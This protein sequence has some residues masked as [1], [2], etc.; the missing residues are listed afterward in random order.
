MCF[1]LGNLLSDWRCREFK[2]SKSSNN[3]SAWK[4][5]GEDP[6]RLPPSFSQAEKITTSLY[7]LGFTYTC[8]SSQLQQ[9]EYGSFYQGAS[10]AFHVHI[11][12]PQRQES[13][14]YPETV[15]K[16]LSIYKCQNLHL[17]KPCWG[18][19]SQTLAPGHMLSIC[20]LFSKRKCQCANLYCF[21]AKRNMGTFAHPFFGC[22]GSVFCL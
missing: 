15:C 8:R 2:T 20:S 5:L 6:K 13:W 9:H 1:V 22:P 17:E 10:C 11:P 19:W 12:F 16:Q 3:Y 18:L 7:K 21:V 14:E 4:E